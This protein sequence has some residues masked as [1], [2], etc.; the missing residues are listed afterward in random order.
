MILPIRHYLFSFRQQK[1]SPFFVIVQLWD[2][3]RPFCTLK[4]N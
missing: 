4:W 1:H 2:L 3:C